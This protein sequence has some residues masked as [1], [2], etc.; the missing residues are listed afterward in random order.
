MTA[1]V[2]LDFDGILVDLN[3]HTEVV[4]AEIRA[5]A[6]HYGVDHDLRPLISS[7]EDVVSILK[8]KND[9]VAANEF[10]TNVWKLITDEECRAASICDWHESAAAMIAQL[11]QHD[12]LLAIYSNNHERA[13]YAALDR[14][15]SPR[16]QWIA[17]C[18]RKEYRTLKPSGTPIVDVLDEARRTH[19]IEHVYLVGDHP[20]DMRSA[21]EAQTMLQARGDDTSVISIGLRNERVTAAN[22]DDAGAWFVV[23]D[24]QE[25][26]ELITTPRQTYS[27]SMVL[28]AFNE[29][30]S[31]RRAIL[32]ACR[33]GERYAS[34]YEV[35]VVDDGSLDGTAE[36]V[37]ANESD[38]IKLVR[39][40][41]NQG[42]GAAMRSGY[43]AAKKDYIAHLPG[44]RQVRPHALIR[45]LPHANRNTIVLSHYREPPS[46]MQRHVVSKLFRQLASTVGGFE[47]SFAGTYLFPRDVLD[48]ISREY[49]FS[50]SFVLSFELLQYFNEFGFV[51]KEVEITPFRREEGQSR[52]F[53][54]KRIAKVAWELGRCRVLKTKARV[55]NHFRSY[56]V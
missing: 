6:Q 21:M 38:Q 29:A 18:A 44:D 20:H 55:R 2:I 4:R 8:K 45:F 35:I 11:C 36:L 28:L 25:A 10:R 32:D 3:L 49:L 39:H 24:L 17:I 33:F 50:Q 7:I 19:D 26:S 56:R 15:K 5:L 40:D 43:W 23:S 47:I 14:L 41:V 9:E 1:L 31:I 13:V 52:E 42:M 37:R 54:A 46:G 22:L 16:E 51:F 30:R 34:S 53:T 27:L 48:R 12:C